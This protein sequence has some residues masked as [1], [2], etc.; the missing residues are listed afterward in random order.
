MAARSPSPA[1]RAKPAEKKSTVVA[2]KGKG[3]SF[4]FFGRHGNVYLYIPNLIGAWGHRRRPREHTQ[5]ARCVTSRSA[6]PHRDPQ[7]C[8]DTPAGYLRVA[9]TAGAFAVAFDSPNLML[10]LY[11]LSF[12][13]DELVGPLPASALS[14]LCGPIL[15][16]SPDPQPT[17]VCSPN[18]GRALRPHVQPD[19][20]FRRCPRHGDGQVQK[21]I[22]YVFVLATSV[23][24]PGPPTHAHCNGSLTLADAPLRAGLPS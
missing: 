15:A 3:K 5:R 6:T 17:R 12:I 22:A 19:H 18:P 10:M 16:P 21:C 2:P 1:G 11:V 9:A 7:S 24:C 8:P 20:H 13:C 14:Y 23:P 4:G